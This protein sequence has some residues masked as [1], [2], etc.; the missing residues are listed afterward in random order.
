[1]A[2][3]Q[4]NGKKILVKQKIS[5]FE[6]LKI[7]KLDRKKVAIEL[8]GL[9]IQKNLYKKKVLKSNDKIEIVHFI[10]GG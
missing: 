6:L 5:L 10:G 3:I 1:M 8:N 7:Y 2:K 9:I 4:L